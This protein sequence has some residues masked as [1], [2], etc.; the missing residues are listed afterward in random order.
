MASWTE[1]LGDSIGSNAFF[2][3][4]S[5]ACW[6]ATADGTLRSFRILGQRV[7]ALG[8]GWNDVA[9]VLPSIDGLNLFVVER[10]GKILVAARTG[11]DRSA[12]SLVLDTNS[13]LVAATRLPNDD[14]IFLDDTGQASLCR[15]VNGDL[16]PIVT[17]GGALALAVEGPELLLATATDVHRLKLDDG[18]STGTALPAPAALAGP[19]V[20]IAG[21]GEGVILCDSTG[22]IVRVD[23]A[24]NVDSFTLALPGS[25]TLCRWHSLAMVFTGQTLNLAEWGHDVSTLPVTVGLDPLV[26]GGWASF[27]VDYAAAGISQSE[28]DWQVAEGAGA[29]TI[30]VA[31]PSGASP[32]A[33]EHRA[34]AGAGAPEFTIMARERSNG[35]VVATRRLRV[36]DVW[37]DTQLGPPMALV[38]PQRVYAKAGWGGGPAGPQNINVHPAPEDFR[39]AVAVFRT[40]GS[41]STINAGTCIS[42]LTGLIAGPGQSVARYFE[43]VSYRNTPASPNPAHPKGTKL[44]LLGGQVFGPIDLDSSW[45]DLFDPGDMDDPWS[46]WNPKGNTWDVLGGAFSTVL[47]DRGL[48]RSVTALADAFMLLVL[49]ATDGPYIVGG[50]TWPAQWSWAFAADSQV[51]W[52]GESWTTFGRRPSVTMPAGFPTGH[53]SPWSP[54]EFLSTLCHELGHNLGCWDQ[55]AGDDY[56]AELGGRYVTGWDLMDDDRPLSHFSLPHRMRL[57]WVSPDWVEVCDFGKNPSSRTVTLQAVE[58]LSRSGPDAGRRAGVEIRIRDGWNYYFEHRRQQAGGVGDQNM[59][60]TQ[61]IVGTDV[62]QVTALEAARPLI[63]ML[64]EDVDGDGPVLRRANSNYRESDVTNPDR[65]NDFILTRQP[66][67]PFDNDAVTVQIDYV[68]AHRAELQITPAPGRGIFKSVDIWLDGPA[69]VGVAAKGK[70]NKIYVRVL[71]RGSKT[72]DAVRIRVQWL[73]FTTAPGPWKALPDPPTQTIPG[74]QHRIFSLD[75]LIPPSVKIGAEEVQHFCVRV[76]VDRYVDPTDPAGSE[77]VVNNNWAQSNFSTDAAGHASPSERR[78]TVVMA[79]NILDRPSFH[80]TVVEQTSEYFRA[81][82][83]HSWRR[84]DAGQTDTTRISYETLAGDPLADGGF[85]EAF[86][87]ASRERGLTNELSARAFLMPDRMFDGARERWGVELLVRAGISTVVRQVHGWGELVTGL[88]TSENGEPVSGGD[89]RLVV[90]P[91]RRPEAQLHSDGQLNSQGEFRLIV[92]PELLGVALQENVL[93]A[94]YYHGTARFTPCHSEEIQLRTG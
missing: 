85:Q 2:D 49:P 90:W 70:V 53:P 17:L 52:K 71:N 21:T 26:P 7:G 19:L 68:G 32:G 13:R 29:A 1:L 4:G 51:Y 87:I 61:A 30:S 60:F 67:L 72:A 31:R 46:A 39:I 81:Y 18:S 34:I 91:E 84:L 58:T 54:D 3:N 16:S 36:V 38:G 62:N 40:K 94:V 75:W 12:A 45:G 59:P 79:T 14:I 63:L 50:K 47:Q 88:V 44:T 73:P 25:T 57:G 92:P 77:I 37:P 74:H 27:H 43:E 78:E 5:N 56:S 8:S 20:A 83:D 28:V 48:G 23:W 82:L 35:T 64:P 9:A 76:D 65:L 15:P 80:S 6:F 10:G 89:V 24:G 33:Y 41:T 11:A 69:G 86:R 42:D 66:S 93:L 55:Y 22:A